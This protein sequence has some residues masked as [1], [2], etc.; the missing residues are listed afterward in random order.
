VD[1]GEELHNNH[2]AFPTSAKF[3]VQ[4]YEFDLGWL[5]IQ[6]LSPSASPARRSSRPG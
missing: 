2:H 4:W 6:A 5:Y 1:R 3:S